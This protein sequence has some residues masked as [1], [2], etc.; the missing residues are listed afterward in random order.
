MKN[1]LTFLVVSAQKIDRQHIQFVL[2]L[3]A[4]GM[5]VIGVGAPVDGGGGPR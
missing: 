1:K 2:T 5:L 4:L 3:I